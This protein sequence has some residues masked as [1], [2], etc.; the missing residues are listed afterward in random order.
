MDSSQSSEDAT[1]L[2]SGVLSS[3]SPPTTARLTVAPSVQQH[4]REPRRFLSFCAVPQTGRKFPTKARPFWRLIGNRSRAGHAQGLLRAWAVWE[5]LS[6]YLWPTQAI[7]GAPDGMLKIRILSYRGNRTRLPDGTLVS[8]G[9]LVAELHCD[10]GA[11]VALGRRRINRYRACRWELRSLARWAVHV[12][13]ATE[14]KAFYGITM[15]WW[16]AARLGFVVRQRD[17]GW[18]SRLDRLFMGGLLL[19]YSDDAADR[20]TRGKTLD[21]Y[22]REVWLSRAELIRR[23]AASTFDPSEN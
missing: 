15:L 20:A 1:I 8:P 5:L 10:N 12:P 21:Q 11:I 17:S 9:D 2:R 22:P 19:L 14:I 23:Y 7:P 4:V 16:A 18:R 6:K 3:V 13:V